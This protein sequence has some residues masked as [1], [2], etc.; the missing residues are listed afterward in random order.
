MSLLI[1]LKGQR[2]DRLVVLRRAKV[3]TKSK[4]TMWECRCDCG[5][6]KDIRARS[7]TKNKTKSCGCLQAEIVSQI[8]WKR[9]KNM[10][11]KWTPERQ[12]LLAVL[13]EHGSLSKDIQRGLN[14]L[15]GS[16]LTIDAVTRMRYRRHVDKKTEEEKKA[17]RDRANMLRRERRN[18]KKAPKGERKT[19]P[20]KASI[21][22]HSGNVIQI[23]KFRARKAEVVSQSKPLLEL[24]KRECHWPDDEPNADG[25]IT[26]C[27]CR[28]FDG[29]SYCE[30]HEILSRGFGTPSERA[31]HKVGKRELENG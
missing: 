12:A 24:G 28:T 15:P 1:N 7:L 27:A 23:E 18:K 5:K 30:A 14:E 31:A 2:F 21:P 4:D 10:E 26:F 29:S 20:A 8:I 19:K 3:H 9:P 25:L 16:Q 11:Q 17:A 22:W 13:H 6:V